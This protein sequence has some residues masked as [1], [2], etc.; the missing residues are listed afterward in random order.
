V[1]HP[2]VPSISRPRARHERLLALVV[3]ATLGGAAAAGTPASAAP[4]EQLPDLRMAYPKEFVL[5][6][7]SS[8]RR[9]L[10][11]T[12][13][14]LNY[15]AGPFEVRAV[16]SSTGESAMSV[17]QRVR[18]TD[19]SWGSR[20]TAAVAK[21]SGD[22]HDHWHVQ[23]VAGMELLAR[24]GQLVAPGRKIG[25]CF[26]DTGRYQALTGSPTSVVYPGSG[27]GTRSSLKLRMGLSVGWGDRYPARLPH[28]WIDVTRVPAGTYYVRVMADPL[29]H[30]RES[31]EANN[32]SWAQIRI[33][34]SGSTVTVLSRGRGCTIPPGPTATPTPTP[35]PTP[36]PTPA[37]QP[38]PDPTPTP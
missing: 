35:V 27:C 34:S 12:T 13:I 4:A 18:R 5:Q 24:D 22:G 38:S 30:Y 20:A 15:G 1:R 2:A 31:N 9:L 10:R 7:T 33:P 26:W 21:Y 11:L 16:R 23:R 14:I 32:C 8:G 37:P 28:Q 19:G 36:A 25:Y 29:N 17:R 3:A 6:R